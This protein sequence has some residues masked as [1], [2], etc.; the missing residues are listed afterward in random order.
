MS[1]QAGPVRHLS[2]QR[3]PTQEDA[4]SDGPSSYPAD[5]G[6][7]TYLLTVRGK[8]TTP[9]V[10]DA[11]E[12]HNT[13]AGAA[14]GV[15]AARALGDLSHNVYSAAGAANGEILFIDFW[16]SLSGLGAFFAD[17]QVQAGASRLFTERDGVVWAPTS[18]FGDFHLASPS[19]RSAAGVGLIRVG[20]TSL[21]AA[22]AA[23]DAYAAATINTGRR[24]GQLS[25]S[26]RSRVANPGESIAPEILGVDVW[27]DVEQMNQYY[28]LGLGFD[29]LGPVFTGQPQTSVWQQAAGDW[30][31]W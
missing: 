31:E 30:T 14:Q 11:R 19:G 23:F 1:I 16:N 18:G 10:A 13:T 24:Y 25:H 3:T 4:M 20:V 6:S 5:A 22:A 9:T 7:A 17:P 8:V 26:T 2:A 12:L 15:A 29:H 27:T 28:E 21:E